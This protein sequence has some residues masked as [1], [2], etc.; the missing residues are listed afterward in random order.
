MKAS[1]YGLVCERVEF[2]GGNVT[3]P[4]AVWS[5][6]HAGKRLIFKE[7]GEMRAPPGFG[8]A[9]HRSQRVG[10][11]DFGPLA[12]RG[13]FV[14]SDNERNALWIVVGAAERL[15]R[16]GASAFYRAEVGEEDLILVVVNDL[17]EVRPQ[18]DE[19]TRL[20]SH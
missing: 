13:L 16:T 7:L 12:H 11:Y 17:C 6:E 18:L 20:S 1:W 2:K 5:L 4:G 10:A 14:H 9:P 8:G 3:L 19:L 15:D